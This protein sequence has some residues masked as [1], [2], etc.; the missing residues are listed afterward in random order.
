MKIRKDLHPVEKGNGRYELLPAS[1]NLTRDEKKAMCGSLRGIRVPSRFTSNIRKLVSMKDL[2]G[3][4]Y[5]DCHVLLTLFL[6][7]A[8]RAINLVYVKMV[9]HLIVFLLQ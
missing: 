3:Y 7:I 6:L 1:Y 5:H 9:N 2:S 8:T 4:N